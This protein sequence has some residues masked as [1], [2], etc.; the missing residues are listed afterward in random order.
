MRGTDI[1]EDSLRRRRSGCEGGKQTCDLEGHFRL[2]V[3]D[4]LVSLDRFFTRTSFTEGCLRVLDGSR[5]SHPPISCALKCY[6]QLP[7]KRKFGIERKIQD[8]L[9][10]VV[11]RSQEG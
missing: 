6:D 7:I 2:E 5:S 9:N 11:M 4:D 8:V 10:A 1:G 3:R